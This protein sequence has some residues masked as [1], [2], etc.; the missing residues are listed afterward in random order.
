MTTKQLTLPVTGMTCASCASRIERGLEKVGGVADAQV[1][2]A[3]EQA[4]VTLDPQQVQP[5]D[6]VT[7]VEASGY[8][9]ISDQIEFPVTG[10]TCASC[11]SRLERA[12]KKSGWRAGR[13]REPGDRA[14]NRHLCAGCHRLY[15]PQDRR[16]GSWLWRHRTGARGKRGGGGVEPQRAGP[17]WPTSAAS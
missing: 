4:T 14:R 13:E 12:L 1:N 2:L 8:G 5:H 7:A 3:S 9:V 16:R 11:A 17:S 6:L 15:G 10:M